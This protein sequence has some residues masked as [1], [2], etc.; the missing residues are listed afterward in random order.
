MIR[1][2][3]W[4]LVLILGA[5]AVRNKFVKKSDSPKVGDALRPDRIDSGETMHR[6]AHCDM[7][8]PASESIRDGELHFCSEQ[9]RRQHGQ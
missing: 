2:L 8:I 3:F 4:L 7:Y 9:H 5:I 1:A 6:C